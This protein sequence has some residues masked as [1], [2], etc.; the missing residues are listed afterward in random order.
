MNQ[1]VM[2]RIFFWQMTP[3]HTH[4][5]IN[6]LLGAGHRLRPARI[7]GML[8]PSPFSCVP[9]GFSPALRRQ[10]AGSGSWQLHLP[11][12]PSVGLCP[13]P[14]CREPCAARAVPSPPTSQVALPT[15]ATARAA[16]L[17]GTAATLCSP[18]PLS[19]RLLGPKI[20]QAQE[21]RLQSP[22]R[23]V[24]Q[25]NTLCLPPCA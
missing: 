20:L 25:I 17:C 7:S 15:R 19:P 2:M 14:L 5:S 3:R 8:S 6:I 9:C 23:E 21:I 18:F 24:P 1:H 10:K 4:F 13:Q 11:C 16:T 12:S 22:G